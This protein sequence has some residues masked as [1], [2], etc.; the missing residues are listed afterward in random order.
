MT[1]HTFEFQVKI[2]YDLMF[3]IHFLSLLSHP[4]TFYFL[5]LYPDRDKVLFTILHLGQILKKLS[6]PV[7]FM[8]S[9][10]YS[11]YNRHNFVKVKFAMPPYQTC[12][13]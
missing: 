1:I 8:G 2:Q 9:A 3:S 10:L 5:P 4:L 6:S 12:M 7:I 13:R 11:D